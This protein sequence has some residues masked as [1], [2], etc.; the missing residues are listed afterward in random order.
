MK[1]RRPGDDPAIIDALVVQRD[2]SDAIRE[3][4]RAATERCTSSGPGCSNSTASATENQH[5]QSATST[6]R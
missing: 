1:P 3:A 5:W 6:A 2:P 4:Q